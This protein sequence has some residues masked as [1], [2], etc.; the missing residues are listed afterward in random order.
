MSIK[1]PIFGEETPDP[2]P[3]SPKP[4]SNTQ[5]GTNSSGKNLA[6]AAGG[7]IVLF[8]FIAALA[9]NTS[10]TS[11]PASSTPSTSPTESAATD[12]WGAWAVTTEG[13]RYLGW[14]WNAATDQEAKE[15]AIGSCRDGGGTKCEAIVTFGSGHAALASGANQW[16]GVGGASTAEE[17]R[18]EAIRG[19]KASDPDPET[20][21]IDKE[22]NF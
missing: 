20:C 22:F 8:I 6:L 4:S 3:V 17:A 5:N 10:G 16:Y 9:T 21:S 13:D 2:A 19:C 7:G 1:G 11:T 12:R 14:S 18:N 15:G